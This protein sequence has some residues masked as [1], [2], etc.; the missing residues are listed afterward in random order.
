MASFQNRSPVNDFPAQITAANKKSETLPGDTY[1]FPFDLPSEYMFAMATMKYSYGRKDGKTTQ[2]GTTYFLPLP[3]GGL[4]ENVG[5]NYSEMELG[6]LAGVIADK[7]AGFAA[8]A[9]GQTPEAVGKMAMESLASAAKGAVSAT[10]NMKTSDKVKAVAA[11]VLPADGKIA[12]AAGAILG[13]VAN[14][15]VTAFFKGV[16]LRSHSF[17]WTLVPASA[18]EASHLQQ[19]INQMKRDALPDKDLGGLALT[20][21]LEAHCKIFTNGSQNMLR[22]KPSFITSI[23]VDYAS[24][25]N[26][27]NEDGQPGV[28]GLTIALKEMDIWT[29]ADYGSSM[30]I[31][32]AGAAREMG[33]GSGGPTGGRDFG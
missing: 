9:A 29:R 5:L 4:T 22:F 25:G 32:S 33:I 15:N 21:P 24:Q 12:G 6:A 27:F 10:N 16:S 17:S 1:S 28:I 13:S 30:A 20:Y 19:M 23:K 7:A 31:A 14:P 18:K 26:F 11:A 8:K 2:I 3:N